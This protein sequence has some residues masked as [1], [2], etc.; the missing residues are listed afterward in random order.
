MLPLLTEGALRRLL[1]RVLL[2]AAPA[3]MVPRPT[4]PLLGAAAAPAE[5]CWL[6]CWLAAAATAIDRDM[7]VTAAQ[8]TA[9]QVSRRSRG[10]LHAP[11]IL[12]MP[13]S[14]SRKWCPA[15]SYKSQVHGPQIWRRRCRAQSVKEHLHTRPAQP[16]THAA[17]NHPSAPRRL[18]PDCPRFF[19]HIRMHQHQEDSPRYRGL[20]SSASICAGPRP[21]SM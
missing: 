2:P 18:K 14:V 6:K 19:S 21:A 17:I 11:C 16:S 15:T 1:L 4:P 3:A 9:R 20:L 10:A 12:I 13:P 5:P 8:G 7:C